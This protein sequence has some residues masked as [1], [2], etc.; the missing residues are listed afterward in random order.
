MRR[1]LIL[2]A[3][4]A[5]IVFLTAG[6][7]SAGAWPEFPIHQG[8]P[9]TDRG[10][11]YYLSWPKILLTWL[12]FL[13]WVRTTDWVNTDMQTVGV[14]D[15]RRWNP[16]VFGTFF[17]VFLMTWLIPIFWLGFI[18][19]LIAYVAPLT[20]FIVL[21]NKKVPNNERVLTPEHLRY[22]FAVRA[23]KV[24][25]KVAYEKRDPREAG[26]PL[27]VFASDADERT[28]S[29]RLISA[30]QMPGLLSAR[31]ILY[32]GLSN[33]ASAILLDFGASS[34]AMNLMID[35]VWIQRDARERESADPALETL[36]VLCGMNPQD[37]QSR[38]KGP[39]VVEYSD[40]RLNATLDTQGT[41]G[42]ERAMI[43]FEE[44]KIRYKNMQELGMRPKMEEEI[45]E[46]LSGEQ[47]LVL[48]AAPPANGLRTATDVILNRTD[49]LTR[50]FMAIEEETH[51]YENV[52]N[53]QVMTYKA[54]DGQTPI[55]ILPK[56]FRMMPNVL[57][58][59]DL[60]NAETVTMLAQDM[61]LEN[62]L[63]L[64]TVRAKD[65]AEAIL[66]VAG[67]GVPPAHLAKV[68][69]GVLSLRLARRL[70]DACKEAY[71]P[72]PQVLAQLGIPEGR[73]QAF[74]RPRP[75]DP[76]HPK[77]I[78]NTCYGIGYYGRTAIFE[79]MLVGDNVR[80]V[81]QTAPQPDLIRAAARK[82]GMKNLQE[83]GILLVAKGV[84]SLPELMRV[85]KQ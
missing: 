36:K 55:N 18:L 85:L 1:S 35:G 7:L 3:V 13:F 61:L 17:G 12:L 64:S 84:T 68:L 21:R 63:V 19:L 65:C 40:Q 73:V 81:L 6:D 20:T 78:C 70:C 77:E 80:K 27:K 58:V 26:P 9:W 49:R 50:D 60:V 37:R 28:V 41:S 43:Q 48:F 67:L 56:V 46:L 8:T 62:R 54:A 2:I 10:A 51:R 24:G 42:G 15:S 45:R 59:R 34:S 57:V 33:R 23:N 83:E 31:E 30:R 74:Y 76:E 4:L 32:E 38:Q 82:D 14:M 39:F 47:G 11:G 66:R 22:W 69:R 5:L 75:P 79:L 72:T 52:E 44:K 71:Q 29:T 25:M 53:V 16:I